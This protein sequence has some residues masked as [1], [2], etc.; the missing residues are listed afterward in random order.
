[1]VFLLASQGLNQPARQYLHAALLSARE[2]DET[3]LQAQILHLLAKLS[4]QVSHPTLPQYGSKFVF[5]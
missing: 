5:I 2:F 1:M 3:S 4:F